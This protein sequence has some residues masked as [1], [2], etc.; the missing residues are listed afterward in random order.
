MRL[1][2]GRLE[3]GSK[4]KT[5]SIAWH[6]RNAE[7]EFGA[8]QAKEL[9][10]HLSNVFSNAPVASHRSATRSSKLRPYGVSKALA[11]KIAHWPEFRPGYACILSMGD[12]DTDEDMFAALPESCH[13][14]STSKMERTKRPAPPT[15]SKAG[16]T[17]REVLRSLL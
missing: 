9:R 16:K 15:G 1:R 14:R 3:L 10:V 8:L 4:R 2:R 5:A 12:D 11:V 6:Y 13:R 17:A 7:P